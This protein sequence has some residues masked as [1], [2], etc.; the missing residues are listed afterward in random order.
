MS[1][2]PRATRPGS[3]GQHRAAACIVEGDS[4]ALEAAEKALDYLFGQAQDKVGPRGEKVIH[5]AAEVRLHAPRPNNARVA[6]AGGNFADHAA[7]MAVKMRGRS[8]AGD[9]YQEIRNGG[10][11]GFWTL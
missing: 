3:A 1:Q 4:C 8:Y 5:E 11:W 9:A 2:K 7:A 10:F 6:C